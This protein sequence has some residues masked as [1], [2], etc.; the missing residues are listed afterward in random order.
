MRN[1][2]LK[3]DLALEWFHARMYV[4][5]LF[6]PARRGERLTAF[7]ARVR[8]GARVVRPDVPLQVTRVAEHFRARFASEFPTVRECQVPDQ[9]RFPAVRLRAQLATVLVG[10]VMVP[11]HQMI[12]QSEK[13]TPKEKNPFA[14]NCPFGES[15][16]DVRYTRR[17]TVGRY[18][19]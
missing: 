9:T 4:R 13:Q 7:R 1:T 14:R 11:G 16:S 8:T 10:L 3:T 12:V 18:F 2:Y 17:V 19:E 15:R 5:V 6:E